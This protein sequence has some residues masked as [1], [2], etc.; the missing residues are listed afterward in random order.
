L[1]IFVDIYNDIFVFLPWYFIALSISFFILYENRKGNYLRSS[2]VF[3]ITANVLVYLFAAV[4]HPESGIFLFFVTT[5]A[6]ALVLFERLNRK[7][8][9][10]FVII[11]A[12]L[13]V[14]AYL[15]DWSPV[16]PPV[17][18]EA[19]RQVNFMINFMLGL[20]SSV[21]IIVFVIERNR[22]SEQSLL[23]N[24]EELQKT[25]ELLAASKGRFES[26][27]EGSG[28]GIYEW[29]VTSN[30]VYVSPRWRSLLG[31][32]SDEELDVNLEFFVNLVH[33][34]DAKKTNQNIQLAIKNRS[35]YVNELRM[36]KNNGEYHWF[37]DTGIVKEVGNSDIVAVG[38]LIDINDR[39]LTEMQLM[40]KNSELRKT[41]DELDRFVYSASHD[42][43]A[44]L[45]TLLGLLEV[46]EQAKDLKE[47]KTY[48]ELMRDRIYTMEGFIGEITDYSR[49]ARLDL[50]LK[51]HTLNEIV[52]KTIDSFDFLAKDA[53]VNFRLDIPKDLKLK[54]DKSRLTVI[55]NNL[56]SNAIKYRD[57]EKKDRSVTISAKNGEGSVK[58][59]VSDNGVGIEPQYLDR[60]FDM[61]FRASANSKGSGLGLYIVKETLEK[62]GGKVD[63]QSTYRSGSKFTVTL[64]QT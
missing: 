7:L 54:T 27:V 44:P 16:P 58:I 23:K 56:V 10:L 47:V 32:E 26:A 14:I 4:D 25:T 8:G 52:A 45:S 3:A 40:L 57:P 64:D 49:N 11:S 35:P 13:A 43:R 31:Y 22:E 59:E 63:C 5:S 39:K 46:A 37:L 17:A 38:S 36:K 12:L 18:N 19:I 62:L 15:G 55:L 42:M 28:A 1:Y 33:P 61:F 9:Y 60:I 24:Q 34:E 41:N 20:I 53:G 51:K 21:I 48:F 50:D 2:L 6:S 30:A 29:S